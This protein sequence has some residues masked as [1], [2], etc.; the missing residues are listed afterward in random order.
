MRNKWRRR[1]SGDLFD[2]GESLITQQCEM[3]RRP[4]WCFE[5]FG[6]IV[7]RSKQIQNAGSDFTI[8]WYE[9][10]VRRQAD[11]ENQSED[12]NWAI[13]FLNET[14]SF[15]F[16]LHS[17]TSPAR[18]SQFICSYLLAFLCSNMMTELRWCRMWLII[19]LKST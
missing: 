14:T 17:V 18:S 4:Y 12:L 6:E 9:F 11:D 7:V 5:V 8:Y 16:T 2:L 10:S 1:K 3:F 15:T 13:K 19:S